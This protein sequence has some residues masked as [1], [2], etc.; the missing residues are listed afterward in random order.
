M[1]A[2]TAAPGCNA[3]PPSF[4]YR[5][6]D[7]ERCSRVR[8]REEGG[9]RGSHTHLAKEGEAGGWGKAGGW[10]RGRKV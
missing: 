7:E 8:G 1:K 6:E 4:S 9:G 3:T 2:H 5:T 10:K